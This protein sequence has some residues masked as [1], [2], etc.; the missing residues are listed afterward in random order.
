M[1]IQS[2]DA[3]S[4]ST[5]QNQQKTTNTVNSNSSFSNTLTQE[6]EQLQYKEETTK[7]LDDLLSMIKTG[8]TVSE[9]EN[10][11]E[12]LA[13]L[14]ALQGKENKSPSMQQE[15]ESMLKDLE[16][17]VLAIKK[18][19]FGEAII[20]Q[21]SDKKTEDKDSI[22]SRI[23]TVSEAINEILAGSV[24]DDKKLQDMMLNVHPD[25]MQRLDTTKY[26]IDKSEY[27]SDEEFNNLVNKL[28]LQDMKKE[29]MA[30]FKSIIED[31]YISNE[32]V[33][34]LSYAQMETLGKFV[35]IEDGKDSYIDKTTINTDLKA[36]TLLSIPI[37]TD[38]ENFNKAVFDMVSNMNDN[39]EIVNFMYGITG[40]HHSAKLIA[41]PE[42]QSKN[43]KNKDMGEVLEKIIDNYNIY[44]DNSKSANDTKYLQ[45]MISKY[46][47][48]FN[49]YQE[50]SGN[51]DKKLE[52]EELI[53]NI[54]QHLTDDFLSIMKTGLTVSEVDKLEKSIAKLEGLIESSEDKEISEVE[55]Q[56]K[57][58]KILEELE[59][60][61]RRLG[62]KETIELDKNIE[63]QNSEGLTNS[64]KEFKSIVSSLKKALEEIKTIGI[65]EDPMSVD[66]ELKLIEKLKNY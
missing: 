14:N 43:Y 8:L 15:I 18:K 22:E 31:Q 1:S 54:K 34:N 45:N 33:E 26:K 16:D 37:V 24:N 23:K 6:Q 40:T 7:L 66:D 60:I 32:E 58:K 42:L 36:G 28:Q 4:S 25:F 53:D 17:A 27:I 61:Y 13:K 50:F 11:Q 44:L 47:D 38:D 10:L 48:L 51:E 57:I 49:L 56:D 35:F 3:L 65:K 2:T 62:V 46:T 12:L 59:A 39:V 21:D 9:L 5:T 19:L 63:T 20:N 52:K 55:I 41:F 30:L 64:M 29:D